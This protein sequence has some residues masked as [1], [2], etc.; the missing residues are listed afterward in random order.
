MVTYAD[1]IA[2]LLADTGMNT[3]LACLAPRFGGI[4]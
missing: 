2:K 4:N 3:F 1:V